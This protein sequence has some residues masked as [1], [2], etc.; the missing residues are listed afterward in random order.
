M[1]FDDGTMIGPDQSR[2]CDHFSAF[3]EA[4]QELYREVL[5]GLEAGR[6]TDDVL[7]PPRRLISVQPHHPTTLPPDP[8]DQYLRI[9]ASEIVF[10]H[11][12]IAGEVFRRAMRRE[13]FVISR[14]G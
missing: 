3:L 8:V 2:L 7:A 6:L 10:W 13:P 5:M 11:N 1:I 9:A 12:R 14:R 4:K